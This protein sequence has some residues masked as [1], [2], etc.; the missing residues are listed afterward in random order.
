MKMG[1]TILS[2]NILNSIFIRNLSIIYIVIVILTGCAHTEPSKFYVLSPIK[3]TAPPSVLAAG[4][5]YIIGVGPITFPKYLNRSQIIRFSS[6]NEV[7]IEE[8]HRWAEPIEQNFSRVL[9]TNLSRLLA[10]SYAIEYPWKRSMNVHFQVVLDIH[11]FEVGPDGTVSLNAHWSMFNLLKNKKHEIVRT[12]NYNKRLGETNYSKIVALQS[13][14]LE[15]LSQ[16]IAKE[17]QK[18]IEQ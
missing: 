18:H 13:Q 15:N 14:A 17:I 4:E 12:F 1:F 3:D 2:I 9:R 11:Q 10:S 5:K 8:F 16:D 7:V 6:D